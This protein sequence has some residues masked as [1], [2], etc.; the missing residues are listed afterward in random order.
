GSFFHIAAA[1]LGL[2]ALL[3]SSAVAFSTVKYLG[4]AYLIFM[5]IRRLALREEVVAPGAARPRS[6]G[7]I[8]YEGMLV[9]LTNPKTA[10]FFLAFLPQFVNPGLG[11]VSLQIVVLGGLFAAMAA[12]SDS[13]YALLTGSIGG[14]LQGH[15]RFVSLQRY[16]SGGIYIALGMATALSGSGRVK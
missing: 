5:G 16:F 2:S 10:L 9:N 13:A 11:G 14:W 6:L 3:A 12:V 1:A 15:A 8:F 7:R 4:A